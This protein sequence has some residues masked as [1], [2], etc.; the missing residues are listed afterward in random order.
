MAL[1]KDW[2]EATTKLY[3]NPLNMTTG[4][5]SP[6]SG[7]LQDP[8]YRASS[9]PFVPEGPGYSLRPSARAKLTV[10]Y[11]ESLSGNG[12]LNGDSD[13]LDQ[14]TLWEFVAQGRAYGQATTY[15]PTGEQKWKHFR[16][17]YNSIKSEHQ[18]Y[19]KQTASPVCPYINGE[20]VTPLIK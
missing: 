7:S 6:I 17:L 8:W 16:G 13:Q 1:I 2:D 15:T 4:Q 10:Y 18:E 11:D 3:L 14:Y 5:G 19:K 12:D 9:G 20:H